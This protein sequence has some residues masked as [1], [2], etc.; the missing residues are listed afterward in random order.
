MSKLTQMPTI[1]PIAN[2]PLMEKT[3]ATI[4]YETTQS[5]NVLKEVIVP[6]ES[7]EEHELESINR[8]SAPGLIKPRFDYTIQ[9][10]GFKP[11]TNDSTY[12]SKPLTLVVDNPLDVKIPRERVKGL[13][14]LKQ[15]IFPVLAVQVIDV[16]ES[17]FEQ[18]N[19]TDD[20]NRYSTIKEMFGTF[21]GIH[22]FMSAFYKVADDLYYP[23][24]KR[25]D[26][27]MTIIINN[28]LSQSKTNARCNSFTDGYVDAIAWFNSRDNIDPLVTLSI[29]KMLQEYFRLIDVTATQLTLQS[30]LVLIYSVEE[31]FTKDEFWELNRPHSLLDTTYVKNEISKTVVSIDFAM[32]QLRKNKPDDY[33]ADCDFNPIQ[34]YL[35]PKGNRFY[36]IPI[37]NVERIMVKYQNK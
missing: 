6:M 31:L 28:F 37:G 10:D 8:D 23:E 32:A 27:W 7:Y 36:Y 16:P 30:N 20:D 12:I 24:W 5:K 9:I 17:L 15:Y 22:K 1:T 35:D 19:L 25:L 3:R 26:K 14:K 13:P 34:L 18:L 2:I 4:A 11:V 33:P 29:G 21:D